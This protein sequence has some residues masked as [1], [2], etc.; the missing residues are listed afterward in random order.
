[1]ARTGRPRGFDRDAAVT[2]AMHA[3][4]QHGYEGASLDTLRRAMGGISSASFYAAFGSKEALY[5]E[6]VDSYLVCHGGIIAA[7]RDDA[8][9]P[10]QR[11]EQAMLA[12]VAVQ[13]QGGHPAGCMIA[14][15]ATIGSQDSS[16]LQSLTAEHREETRRAIEYC[17]RAAAG[18]KTTNV[19]P[20]VLL[21]DALLLGIAIQARDGVPARDIAAAV[22]LAMASWDAIFDI[23][24]VPVAH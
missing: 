7:L 10:R 14:L 13:T 18:S 24:E 19:T 2:A 22:V 17:V 23:A 9:A 1:M 11:L 16:A 3:F 5:R 20:L 15:S 21:Y 4:W 12:S 6:C 8:V